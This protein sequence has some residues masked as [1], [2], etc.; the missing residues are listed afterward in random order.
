[1]D[2]LLLVPHR[3]EDGQEFELRRIRP[4]YV[5][6]KFHSDRLLLTAQNT[7]AATQSV[8]RLGSVSV[9]MDND[10]PPRTAH[11]S[12]AGRI[13]A[14]VGW[15]AI[16]V[17][18]ATLG[19]AISVVGDPPWWNVSRPYVWIPMLFALFAAFRD[20][21]FLVTWS[22]VAAIELAVIGGF[23]RADG[24]H[25]LGRYEL[26]LG[27]SGLGVAIAALSGRIRPGRPYTD[28]P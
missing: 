5:S 27:L 19:L 16:L 17:V 7:G 8:G 3:K 9:Q 1:M 6:S 23:D 11:T 12:K 26:L 4:S 15:I 28:A 14:G 2:V 22:V 20:G 18:M 25:A 24:R 13:M 10:E 21:R